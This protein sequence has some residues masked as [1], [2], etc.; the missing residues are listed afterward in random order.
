MS[1]WTHPMCIDCWNKKHPGRRAHALIESM[2]EEERCCF[3]GNATRDGIY[4]RE[5]PAVLDLCR[6]DHDGD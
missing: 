5:D 4:Y 6:G 3:C 2:R 1:R